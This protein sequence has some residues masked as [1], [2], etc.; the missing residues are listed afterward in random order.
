MR[1]SRLALAAALA[2]TAAAC[3]GYV[4]RR[5]TIAAHAGNAVAWNRA[6]HTI[7]PWPASAVRTEIE[8]SG[9]RVVDAIE[10][11]EAPKPPNGNGGAPAIMA[12]PMGMPA[13]PP[14]N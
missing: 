14:A 9:R 5:E 7:D 2:Y 11:Y 3:T 4:E 13:P 12:I 10:R 8:V 6:V 1:P